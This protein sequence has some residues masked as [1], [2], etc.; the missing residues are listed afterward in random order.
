M[1]NVNH[2]RARVELLLK[3]KKM[4]Q[5]ALAKIM[6]VQPQSLS[7]ILG[8]GS[9]RFSTLQKIAAALECAPEDL[10]KE[11]SPDEYAALMPQM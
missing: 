2:F 10:I 6:G 11:V 7:T 9:P 5:A 4:S 8:H 3:Q 1:G